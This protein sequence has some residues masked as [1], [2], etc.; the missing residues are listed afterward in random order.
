MPLPQPLRLVTAL[1]TGAANRNWGGQPFAVRSTR[2]VLLQPGQAVDDL[3]QRVMDGL[4]C[5]AVAFVGIA[6]QR[7]QRFHV[8]GQLPGNHAVIVRSV[9]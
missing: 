5:L 4:E 7:F 2:D 8:L 1:S 6:R 3:D 9:L